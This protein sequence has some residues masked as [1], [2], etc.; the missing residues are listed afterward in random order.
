[1][2]HAAAAHPVREA[3][4]ARRRRSPLP[5]VTD[6]ARRWPGAHVA[7]PSSRPMPT[8]CACIPAC[9]EAIPV[10]LRSLQPRL[11]SRR[12]MARAS[13]ARGARS[14]PAWDYVVDSQGC[15]RARHR[16]RRAGRALRPRPASARER[17]A[18]RFYDVRIPVAR[19]MHAVERNR[20]LVAQVFGY[21]RRRRDPTT[22]STSRRRPPA[23]APARPYIVML[24][25]AS[26][27][28]KLWPESVLGG[29]RAGPRAQ[30]TRASSRGNAAERAAAHRIALDIP[31]SAARPVGARRARRAARA[32]LGRRRLD[33]GLTHLAVALGARPSASTARRNRSSRDCT[34]ARRELGGRDA[35]VGR[36]R[37][38][39]W[40]GRRRRRSREE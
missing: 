20:R 32:S 40:A 26:H 37:G 24:H 23:W 27:R 1:M 36:G 39:R 21:S 11:A 22:A 29:A 12:R 4:L 25:A 17:L 33:T 13:R 38:A 16:L 5:A 34:G 8:S 30:A 10:N 9:R 2:R 28:Q 7:G 35:A 18:A 3:V 31:S 6:L 15:S 19:R 14:A